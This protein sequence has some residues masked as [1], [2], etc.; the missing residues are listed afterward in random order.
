MY[1]YSSGGHGTGR[2]CDSHHTHGVYGNHI[3]KL[4]KFC[5]LKGIQCEVIE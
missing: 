1:S 4:V 2:A 3:A 5:E